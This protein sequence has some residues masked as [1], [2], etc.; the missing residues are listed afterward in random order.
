MTNNRF[1][2]P[3]VSD[4]ELNGGATLPDFKEDNKP[5]FN[6]ARVSQIDSIKFDENNI[7]TNFPTFI[8]PVDFDKVLVELARRKAGD[9][10]IVSDSRLFGEIDGLKLPITT[11]KI[12]NDEVLEMLEHIG[13]GKSA[14]VTTNTQPVKYI[15]IVRSGG[16]R[17]GFRVLARRTYRGGAANNGRSL[18]LRTIPQNPPTISE[19]GI[20]QEI[21]DMLGNT[22]GML[23]V[24]GGTGSGKTTTCAALIR[25]ILETRHGLSI[26]TYEDPMEHYFDTDIIKT[27]CLIEQAEVN[28]LLDR[29][30]DV[31][32]TLLR[33]GSDIYFLGEASDKGGME[34]LVKLSGLGKFL[35]ATTHANSITQ[36]FSRIG[37]EFP[38]DNRDSLLSDVVQKTRGIVSQRLVRAPKGPGRTAVFGYLEFSGF[39]RDA[40]SKVHPD[41]L[42]NELKQYVEKYGVSEFVDATRKYEAGFIHEEDFRALERE[43][44]T[45]E[46]QRSEAKKIL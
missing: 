45:D 27:E 11:R 21:V 34:A 43:F 2:S 35:I 26:S 8:S 30:N 37:K 18:T 15:H 46:I 38:I 14:I 42:S 32:P 10:K 7:A 19:L 29:W 28:F 3:E 17:F 36:T 1:G 16:E 5:R 39:I 44:S 20:P 6:A 13:R 4:E 33:S 9:I 24:V 12:S 40:L 31:A 22:A 25:H 41:D 23:L